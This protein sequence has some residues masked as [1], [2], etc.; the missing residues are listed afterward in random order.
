[1][2]NHFLFYA[3]FLF[4]GFLASC[5]EI[6]NPN[7][8][9]N[10]PSEIV[11]LE[12]ATIR[13]TI[14]GA[15]GTRVVLTDNEQNRTVKV[16]WK[17][18][19]T[20]S[21]KV[22]GKTYTFVYNGENKVFDYDLQNGN[23]PEVF[24]STEIVT[25]KYPSVNPRGYTIQTGTLDDTEEFIQMTANLDVVA[26]QSTKDLELSFKHNTSLIK[27][28][29]INES[30]KGKTVIVN[31]YASGLLSDGNMITT[32]NLRGNEDGKVLAYL[33]VPA[34]ENS[35]SDCTIYVKVIDGDL[36]KTTLSA[37]MIA[38]GKLYNITKTSFEKSN[39]YID[40]GTN[41]G[42][43]V[44][45][46]GVVWAPV[47]CGY[48]IEHTYGKLYQWGRKYGQGYSTRF[49]SGPISISTGQSASKKDYFYRANDWLSPQ[50]DKLWNSGT[51]DNPQKTEY[52]P[53]PEGWRVPTYTELKGLSLNS[54]VT[55]EHLGITGRF[56][57]GTNAYTEG[58]PK[59]FLPAA[60]YRDFDGDLYSRGSDG[61]YWSSTPY[62]GSDYKG[63][64]YISFVSHYSYYYYLRASGYSVRC[65]KD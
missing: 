35:L 32:Q 55:T 22:N 65:V 2:K 20:F 33:A 60:G 48:D 36:Y 45:I 26:N 21:I 10:E 8:K 34:A 39:A 3:F 19:D 23:F 9:T 25:A 4:G 47:N 6:E 15:F 13:A 11:K 30:F 51:E 24:A 28:N 54:S 42:E 62:Y 14:E 61:I 38:A 29:L 63:A 49:A 50:N 40:N 56:F 57:Y 31:F 5:S 53:C 37:K 17:A 46:D 1:M 58:V 64:N 16:D 52:D 41:Y 59:V 43:G 7:V 18:G 27:L 44:E 12:S